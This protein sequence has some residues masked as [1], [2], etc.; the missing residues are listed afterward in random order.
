MTDERPR[1]RPLDP[2]PVRAGSGQQFLLRDPRRLSTRKVIVPADIAFLLAQFDGSRT[3]REAQVSYVR[4]LG[5][6]ITSE[7]IEDLLR[8]LDEALLLDT[9]RFRKFAAQAEADFVALPTGPMA[10][11]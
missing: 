3:V 7:R 5:S 2:F 11:G 1:L 9:D 4:R 8:Q 10:R 6:L